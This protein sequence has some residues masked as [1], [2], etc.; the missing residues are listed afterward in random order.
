MK[1]KISK[2]YLHPESPADIRRP[3]E[4]GM[5]LVAV[6][7][8]MSLM[9]LL[10]LAVTFTAM[11]D[12]AVTS[13]F[14]NL[15]SGFYAAE[16][17]VGNLHRTLRSEKFVLASLPDP[18]AVTPGQPT[19]RPEDFVR[20]AEDL[21]KTHE[22]FPN[23]SAYRTQA[24]IKEFIAPYPA[25][26]TNPAHA[27]YRIQ[28]RDVRNPRLGQ[29]EPYRVSYEIESIGEG[30]SGLNGLV[31]L[32]EEGVINFRLIVSAEG[33]GVRVGA[34][35]EFALFFDRFDPYNPEGPF[36]YQGLGPGDRFSG[37][38]HTNERFGFWTPADGSN[39][40]TF[41]GYVSQAYKTASYYRHGAGTPPPPVDSD[42][43][44]VDGV[45][46]AP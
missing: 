7:L 6:L 22:R 12:G 10:G 43:D 13:N 14:R 3:N 5:A 21:L 4:K 33:G 38:I 40:P 46:V 15:T 20:A 29:T 2:D 8:I 17:G 18:P 23:D 35:S 45:L 30:I 39:A 32:V 1:R 42:S 34:F 25:T 24:R 9:L 31:T 27:A 16:A 19:L 44:V 26:D 37:R 11:S 36:I 28:Y 41:R